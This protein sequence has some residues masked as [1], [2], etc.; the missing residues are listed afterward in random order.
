M[1]SDGDG[2]RGG[3]VIDDACTYWDDLRNLGYLGAV[4]VSVVVWIYILA[5]TDL[6]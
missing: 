4:S 5:Y 2:E 3:L 6:R 1:R